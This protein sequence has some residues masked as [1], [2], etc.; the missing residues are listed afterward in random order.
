MGAV[1]FLLRVRS[2]IPGLMRNGWLVSRGQQ[3]ELPTLKAKGTE[4][5][6]QEATGN[7]ICF[8]SPANGGRVV[9]FQA[10]E[11][12]QTSH[13]V[14]DSLLLAE[15]V[16]SRPV[17]REVIQ[18]LCSELM[19]GGESVSHCQGEGTAAFRPRGNGVITPRGQRE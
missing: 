12:E 4:R 11:K 2:T 7:K 6:S 17:L 1:L 3:W 10:K 15:G 9:L 5:P 19:G 8:L 13:R 18:R 14:K 16:G